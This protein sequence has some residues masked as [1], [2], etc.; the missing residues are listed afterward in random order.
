MPD[1]NSVQF[2]TILI[3]YNIQTMKKPIYKILPPVALMLL[4]AVFPGCKGE[5]NKTVDQNVPL[6]ADT[7]TGVVRTVKV[8][9]SDFKVQMVSNGKVEATN[10]AELM[11]RTNG[12]ISRVYVKNGQHV[13]K[14]Q[15][16]ASLDKS[17]LQ[18]DIAKKEMECEM[19]EF[20][21]K[22]ILIGQGYSYEEQDKIPAKI[23]RLAMIKSGYLRD[24]KELEELKQHLEQ[25]TLRAPF[26]GLVA[27]LNAKP[28]SSA[29]TEPVC[30]IVGQ[31]G[32]E[33]KFP[34]VENEVRLVRV[35]DAVTILT[36]GDGEKPLAG[37]IRA[38]NPIVD[39]D[40][41]ITVEAT[42][43]SGANLIS[44]MSVRVLV[45]KTA[46]D[47]IVV[48]KTAVVR[49]SERDVIFTVNDNKAEW[50]YVNIGLENMTEYTITDGL[51]PGMEVIISGSQNLADGSAV[52]VQN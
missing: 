48:P 5:G 28:H 44:G 39:K 36:Y 37:R 16:I 49:R 24:R 41:L 2:T 6:K 22:D 34:L 17:D 19:S 43:E 13:Q 47:Q 14:G 51:E 40:G 12:I 27:D 25:T 1:I 26:A 32:M 18:G 23:L 33:V 42:V 50:H 35:G 8:K 31:S 11:F 10:I 7:I 45:N 29:G 21:L 9:P 4:A 15:A 30:R 20:Q 3:T 52:K 38:I 46:P